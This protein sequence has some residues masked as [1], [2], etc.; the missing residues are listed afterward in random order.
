MISGLEDN[1]VGYNFVFYVI[2]VNISS[3][4]WDNML[5]ASFLDSLHV[6][7]LCCNLRPIYKFWLIRA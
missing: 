1:P 3:I 2:K 5:I 6:K 4:S 7:S